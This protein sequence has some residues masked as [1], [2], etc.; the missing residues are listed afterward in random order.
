MRKVSTS[1]VCLLLSTLGAVNTKLESWRVGGLER[2]FF[3]YIF[4]FLI[5]EKYVV[6]AEILLFGNK[7]KQIKTGPFPI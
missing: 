7:Q 5:K 1:F 3:C 4:L 6:Q 2:K